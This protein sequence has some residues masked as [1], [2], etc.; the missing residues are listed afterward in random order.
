MARPLLLAVDDDAEHLRLIRQELENRYGRDYRIVCVSTAPEVLRLLDEAASGEVALLLVDLWLP[1]DSGPK[2]FAEARARQPDAKRLALGSFRRRIDSVLAQEQLFSAASAGLIDD[3]VAPPLQPGDEHFHVGIT[4]L[5]YQWWQSHG[6]GLQLVRIVGEKSSARVHQIRD[7]LSRHGLWFEFVDVES[8][9]GRQLLDQFH[10]DHPRLPVVIAFSTVYENPSNPEM[11]ED[12]GIRTRAPSGRYDVIIIGGGP[13]GLSAAVYGASE[14]L[15]TLLLERESIG[16]QAGSSSSIRNYLGFPRGITGGDL[17]NR[18]FEQAR[19]FGT[20]LVYGEAIALDH[21]GHDHAV[22][23]RNGDTVTSRAVIIATG[24]AYRR[25]GIENLEAF[26][27]LG[28][29]Y[30]AAAAEA[31]AMQGQAVHIVGGANS[32]GQAALHLARHASQVTIIV[33]GA[34]LT[35]T[36]SDYLIRAIEAAPNI[37]VRY[38]TE[39]VDGSGDRQLTQLTLRHKGPGATETVPTSGLFVLIGADPHTLW[40]PEAIQRD[41]WGYLLTGTDLQQT[42]QTNPARPLSRPALPFETSLP[43]VFAVGDV[44]HG[45]A[46]RVAAAVGDGSVAIRLVHR[47]LATL[48]AQEQSPNNAAFANAFLPLIPK[49]DDEVL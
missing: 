4:N 12:F 21:A 35:Q 18:A 14:G 41:Q 11:A 37:T 46:K 25:L 3:W 30:G 27:G 45:E 8:A 36:M 34:T 7:Q 29:F 40:L 47:Y 20:D 15:R 31:Q 10:L 2:L 32:A 42:S 44:R 13:A 22:K 28:V 16:G 19:M 5:L 49:P 6:R 33:R 23:M 39:V 48:T 26:T 38:E 9:E 17:A 43:G 24:A 1:E